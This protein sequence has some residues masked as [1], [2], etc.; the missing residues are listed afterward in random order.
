M[1]NQLPRG[2]KLLFRV[3]KTVYRLSGGV[4]GH[5]LSPS[6]RCLLLTTTGAKSGLARV[7]PLVYGRDGSN[8]VLI[9]S[10]GGTDKNPTWLHNLRANPQVHIQVGRHHQTMTAREANP[11]ERPRLWQ[12]MTRIY[13]GY[14]GYQQKT[15][16]QIPIVVLEPV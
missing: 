2:A 12:L 5:R 3:H 11:E 10:Q 13:G 9:A 6:L 16:R 4:I 1:A 14:D 15:S 8:I 7:S